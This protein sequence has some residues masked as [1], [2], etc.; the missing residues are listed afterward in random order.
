LTT[1]AGQE[2]GRSAAATLSPH[3]EMFKLNAT[4]YS[5]QT[6]YLQCVVKHLG[7]KT[8]SWIRRRD[9][10]IL[11][12]GNHVYTSDPRVSL[13][14]QGKLYNSWTLKI[15]R[16]SKKD[17]G[18]YECQVNTEPKLTASIFLLVFGRDETV[19]SAWRVMESSPLQLDSNL[20]SK[21]KVTEARIVGPVQ[22]NLPEGSIANF[23][24]MISHPGLTAPNVT[25][26]HN[27]IPVKE[28][29][30]IRGGINIETEKSLF[31][32]IS[33]LVIV[34]VVPKDQG[35]YSC[36]GETLFPASATLWV[37]SFQH[38]S[39]SSSAAAAIDDDDGADARAGKDVNEPGSMVSIGTS[40]LLLRSP[41][42]KSYAH[43]PA[44]LALFITYFASAFLSS[45]SATPF[46]LALIF[47]PILDYISKHN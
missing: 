18:A 29:S 33:K 14:R 46:L 28:S 8:V 39:S 3:I 43:S 13:L 16:V 42:L 32:T 2:A 12:S 23:T 11:T 38:S 19:H 10:H 27:D 21:P 40:L 6:A 24:C 31:S 1:R 44:A 34:K 35:K 5:G 20:N 25:W 45:S 30:V 15:I 7:D 41:D 37:Q 17:E 26:L 36:G 9:L 47:I 4:A 22:L